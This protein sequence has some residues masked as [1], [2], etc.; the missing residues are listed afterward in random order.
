MPDAPTP[1][2]SPKSAPLFAT[3]RR[4]PRRHCGP[5]PETEF[6][7]GGEAHL[8][9]PDPATATD[10]EWADYLFLRANRKGLVLERWYHAHGCQR[11]FNAARDTVTYRFLAVYPMG[12]EPPAAVR[13]RT[14]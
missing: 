5:R 14:P 10:E 12:A 4:S 13:D 6:R 3:Q 9:R 2:A 11:W 1:P 8:R 7:C